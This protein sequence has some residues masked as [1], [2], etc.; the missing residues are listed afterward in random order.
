[1]NLLLEVLLI[2]FAGGLLA[3]LAGRSFALPL[4]LVALI[5]G[6]GVLFQHGMPSGA[7]QLSM[8]QYEL[9]WQ[10][11]PI[12]RFFLILLYSMGVLTLL[13]SIPIISSRE[14]SGYF[15]MNFLFAI[16]AM[17]GILVSRDFLSLFFF[18]EIMTWSSY[19]LVIFYRKDTLP[20]GIM[21]FVLS[22]AGAYGMLMAISMIYSRTGSLDMMILKAHWAGMPAT[23]KTTVLALFA[24]AFGVKAGMMPLHVWAPKAYG[25]APLTFTALFSGMMSKMG[26]YGFILMFFLVGGHEA[27]GKIISG[28]SVPIIIAWLGGITAVVVTIFAIIQED[29]R[30]LTAY[31]SL[32][33]VGYI[34]MG[35]GIGSELGF[36]AALF[37][38]INHALFKGALFLIVAA[39]LKQTGTT[40]LSELGG[41]IQNMPISFFITLISII[42]LAGMPPLSGLVGKWMLY[43]ALIQDHQVLLAVIA[44]AA[45]TAAFL[46]VYRLIFSIFL[47]QRPVELDHVKEVSPLLWIP[48]LIFSAGMIIFGYWPQPILH[49]TEHVMKFIWGGQVSI[50]TTALL[51]SNF[52]QTNVFMVFNIFG[53]AFIVIFILFNLFYK[54][55]RFVVGQ[56]YVHTSGELP[57]E[58]TNLH[59]AVDF[60]KPFERAV[61]PIVKQSLHRWYTRFG[62]NME[63]LFD[64]MRYIYTGNGQTYAFFVVLFLVITLAFAGRIVGM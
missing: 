5:F 64:A 41:L 51:T 63:A 16:L 53:T 39:V 44:F 36:A 42:T 46:Y 60:Y 47:G 32:A 55:S 4:S 21:Y 11:M 45:S 57:T 12:S 13:A 35:L 58:T 25:Q 22:V 26:V 6:G 34:L 43:E 18:W 27:A 49:L 15:A 38:T 20:G 17:T 23:W 29:A 31:S 59:Y 2:L 50:P 19:L 1:M 14:R 9:L 7:F 48:G 52:G 40:K 30:Y 24:L 28:T 56:L 8:G 62:I 3:Y 33:Q 10:I 37:H 54:R 61:G